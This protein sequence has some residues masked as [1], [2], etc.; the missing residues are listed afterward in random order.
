MA[1][2]QNTYAKRKREIE[3]KLKAE[4]KRE[5]RKKRAESKK[6]FDR[7]SDNLSSVSES[8]PV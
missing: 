7:H 3:K 1:K 2:Q 4:D 8:E 5:R 6:Q